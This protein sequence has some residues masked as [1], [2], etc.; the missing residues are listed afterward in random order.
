MERALGARSFPGL[1]VRSTRPHLALEC[2]TTPAVGM[3]AQFAVEHSNVL[4]RPIQDALR[5]TRSM[6]SAEHVTSACP[7]VL[8]AWRR[9]HRACVGTLWCA[10][11]CQRKPPADADAC[12]A[13]SGHLGALC[14]PGRQG[15]A[16]AD[17]RG[18]RAVPPAHHG[19]QL[20]GQPRAGDRAP[21]GGC[22]RLHQARSA[23]C[24][25]YLPR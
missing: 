5:R 2:L 17:P 9:L 8:D 19:V 23:R 16:A 4:R 13:C 11:G 1:P 18:L 20:P 15:Q 10:P 14:G 7:C 24:P 21:V 25:L 22:R 6:N 3:W 12:L